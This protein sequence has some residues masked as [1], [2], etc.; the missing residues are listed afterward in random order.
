MH[1]IQEVYADSGHPTNAVLDIHPGGHVID[2]PQLLKFFD[3]HLGAGK[4][5]N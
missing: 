4:S 3:E 5:A 2:L 1:E